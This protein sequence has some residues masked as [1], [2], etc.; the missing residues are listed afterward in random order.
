MRTSTS[1][2]QEKAGKLTTVGLGALSGVPG[3]AVG[4]TWQ[5]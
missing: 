5:T 4:T 3:L 1:Q 2:S